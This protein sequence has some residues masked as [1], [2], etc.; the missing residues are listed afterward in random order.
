[1][2]NPE[3][4]AWA[5]ATEGSISLV[6]YSTPSRNSGNPTI[7]PYINLGNTNLELVERFRDMVGYGHVY[8]RTVA[9]N[10]HKPTHYWAAVSLQDCLSFLTEIVDYLPIKSEQAEIVIDF[11]S[12]RL[13]RPLGSRHPYVEK[14]WRQV[15][16]MHELNRVGAFVE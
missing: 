10:G 7:R 3:A 11:C 8:K 9:K 14:D 4:V 1:M 5:I 13:K 2:K 6:S 12:R 16:V 15:A